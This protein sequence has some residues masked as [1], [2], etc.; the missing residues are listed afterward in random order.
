MK[1]L[2]RDMT[3]VVMH[4]I[5]CVLGWFQSSKKRSG[6]HNVKLHGEAVCAKTDKIHTFLIYSTPLFLKFTC[7]YKII[8]QFEWF[9]LEEDEV[10]EIRT[11]T[12]ALKDL[13]C[14]LEKMQVE[15]LN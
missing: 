7:F 2:K 15:T 10:T 8:S 4:K 14:Y 11:E 5:F 12:L 9:L 6:M 3:I 13:P 1:I